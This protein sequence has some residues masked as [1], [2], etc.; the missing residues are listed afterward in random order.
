MLSIF[1]AAA[2]G[3]SR[4]VVEPVRVGDAFA[5]LLLVDAV[6][7]LTVPLAALLRGHSP[8]ATVP[9]RRK[10]DDFAA[11]RAI[12]LLS[13]SDQERWAPSRVGVRVW[14]SSKQKGV[15]MRIHIP[16]AALGLTL[17]AAAPAAAQTSPVVTAPAAPMATQPVQAAG[18]ATTTRTRRPVARRAAG[19]IAGR[20]AVATRRTYV[21]G[22]VVPPA[23]TPAAAVAAAAPAPGYDYG[24]A[25]LA[26]APVDGA[27][28]YDI[29][30]APVYAP[31]GV[32][33]PAAGPAVPV[34]PVVPAYQYIYQFDRIL[35]VDPVTGIAMQALPR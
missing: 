34:A 6:V 24:D 10:R 2:I 3:S 30:P 20:R 13:P 32:V 21:S 9:A 25:A 12:S 16:C 33:A 14:S 22:R 28:Y 5:A 31:S 27:P 23:A 35:V 17:V 29:A 18:D 15:R 11:G 19:P 1:Y 8:R 4:V 26:P 7:L